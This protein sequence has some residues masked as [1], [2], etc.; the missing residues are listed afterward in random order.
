[1]YAS[2]ARTGFVQGR[3]PEDSSRSR[4][5]VAASRKQAA[6]V[7]C[8]SRWG[9]SDTEKDSRFCRAAVT[10]APLSQKDSHRPEGRISEESC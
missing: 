10:V 5:A 4:A 3:N 9:E 1:M 7:S 2:A 6:R 8:A